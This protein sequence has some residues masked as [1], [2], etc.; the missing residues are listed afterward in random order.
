MK[1]KEKDLS[2]NTPIDDEIVTFKS[3]PIIY[4]TNFIFPSADK[5]SYCHIGNNKYSSQL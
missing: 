3:N 4:K 1:K 5:T 2:A